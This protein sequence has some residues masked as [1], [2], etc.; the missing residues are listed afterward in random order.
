MSDLNRHCLSKE[1]DT[2]GD[3]NKVNSSEKKKD[4]FFDDL[5]KNAVSQIDEVNVPSPDGDSKIPGLPAKKEE[6]DALEDNASRFKKIGEI[7]KLINLQL[8]VINVT[9]A[10]KTLEEYFI[11]QRQKKLW[12]MRRRERR[13]AQKDKNSH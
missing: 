3:S 8:K 10:P 9:Y 5:A 6:S 12:R 2:I 7:V 11:A 13:A 4:Y 1:P